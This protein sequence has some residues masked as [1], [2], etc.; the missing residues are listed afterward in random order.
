MTDKRC[1]CPM[2]ISLTGDGCRYC[3]PQEH[4]ERMEEWLDEERADKERLVEALRD[5]V[6][7]DDCMSPKMYIAATNNARLI[8][9]E[10][11]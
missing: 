9:E 8:L 11:E 7:L 4:I 5:M 1:K 2:A 6:E 10:L 3:Q